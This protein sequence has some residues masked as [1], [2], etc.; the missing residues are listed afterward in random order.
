MSCLCKVYFAVCMAYSTINTH[1]KNE[2][3][4]STLLNQTIIRGIE[5]CGAN[6]RCSGT[7][8]HN[9]DTTLGQYSY[10]ELNSKCGAPIATDARFKF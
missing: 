4:G 9:C 3:C 2:I 5:K 7:N 1:F 8:Y 10:S 6:Q